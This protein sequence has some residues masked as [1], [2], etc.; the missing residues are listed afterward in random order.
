MK[1]PSSGHQNADKPN[2]IPQA[3]AVALADVVRQ[4]YAH[5][6]FDQCGRRWSQLGGHRR[7][8]RQVQER[9]HRGIDEPSYLQR[10]AQRPSQRLSLG[11]YPDGMI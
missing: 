4:A 5:P 9:Q 11:Q 6:Q 2:L 1:W 3:E 10:V 7:L 8:A